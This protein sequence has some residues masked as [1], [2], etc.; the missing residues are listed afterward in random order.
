MWGVGRESVGSGSRCVCYRFVSLVVVVV[1]FV[2]RVGCF[3]NV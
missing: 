3:S 1:F 2:I